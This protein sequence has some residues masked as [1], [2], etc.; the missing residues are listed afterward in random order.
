LNNKELILS[1]RN[2]HKV[3]EISKILKGFGI[4]ITSLD[5]FK[6]A[7]E[8]EEDGDTLAENASKKARTIATHLGKWALADDTGLEVEYLN[9]EPGVYSARWAGEECSYADNNKK[10]LKELAGVPKSKRKAC[11]KCVI[12]LSSPKGKVRCVEGRINGIIAEKEM[13]SKGFGYDPLFVVPQYGKSFAQLGSTIKNKISHRARALK[14]ARK[15]I[16]TAF[17]KK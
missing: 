12:A 10:L 5:D 1:T 7:P 4:E 8:V 16:K 15:L 14:K 9:G 17:S 13:G 6:D 11:F 3:G 2:K